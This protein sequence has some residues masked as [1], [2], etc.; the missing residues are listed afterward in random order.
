M[1][2]ALSK[3]LSYRYIPFMLLAIT[4]N[5]L[6]FFFIQLM[7][8]GE[9]SRGSISKLPEIGDFIR[10]SRVEAP[11]QTTEETRQIEQPVVEDELPPPSVP[12]PTIAPPAPSSPVS[13]PVAGL[14]VKVGG[15]AI[16]SLRHILGVSRVKPAAPRIATNL[17]PTI[18]IPP[19]YPQ[20]AL[21][22][23]I[24][25]IVTVEFTIGTDGS[26]KDPKIV[27][28]RPEKV[29]DNAVL[30]AIMKWKYPPELENGRP[31]EIRAR[32]DIPFVLEE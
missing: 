24:E 21:N 31:V 27:K 18:R 32:I 12:M 25:G 23:G 14:D 16:P 30:T 6:V 3:Y 29:F 19:I 26:V 10:V 8:T 22:Q 9:Y 11:P 28:A 13:T 5:I 17:V 2:L 1:R 15:N 20:Q 4:I 7:V